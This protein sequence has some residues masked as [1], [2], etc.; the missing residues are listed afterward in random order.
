MGDGRGVARGSGRSDRGRVVHLTGRR[1]RRRRQRADLPDPH[2]SA[3]EGPDALDGIAGARV[4]RRGGLEQ[5][6]HALG[7][8]GGPRG[9]NAPVVLAERQRA[10]ASTHLGSI[11]LEPGRGRQLVAG[12]PQG[13]F[14]VAGRPTSLPRRTHAKASH[15]SEVTLIAGHERHA[16]RERRGGDHRVRQ[17]DP[18]RSPQPAGLLGEVAIDRDLDEGRQQAPHGLLV[19]AGAGEELS[20]GDDGAEDAVRPGCEGSVSSQV[21][22]EDVGVDEDV[23]HSRDPTRSGPEP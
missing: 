4:A 12:R 15:T 8:V 7:A 11:T 5:R 9:K 1:V 21:I 20:A 23:S 19:R 10:R 3:S 17:G 14:R 2:L 22:D 6:E 13:G 16:K 18:S